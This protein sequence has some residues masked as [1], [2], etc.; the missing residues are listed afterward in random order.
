MNKQEEHRDDELLLRLADGELEP[1]EADRA[2]AHL[3]ACWRCRTRFED[4]QTSIADYMR[5]R[6]TVMKPL[7]PPPPQPWGSLRGQL[8]KVDAD[9]ASPRRWRGNRGSPGLL[10]VAPAPFVAVGRYMF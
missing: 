6:E 4:L 5:Y 2:Q 1:K 3:K 10:G 8:R 9:I 7:L